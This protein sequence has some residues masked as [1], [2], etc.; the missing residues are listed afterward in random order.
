MTRRLSLVVLALLSLGACDG[1]GNSPRVTP[2]DNTAT[3][4]ALVA[5][6][7]A[8]ATASDVVL[9][10]LANDAGTGLTLVALEGSGQ[11]TLVIEANRVRY[12]PRCCDVEIDVFRYV[13]RDARG[14]QASAEVRV[15]VERRVVLE[16]GGLELGERFALEVYDG[17]ATLLPQRVVE[18]PY[19]LEVPFRTGTALLRAEARRVDAAGRPSVRDRFVSVLGDVASLAARGGVDGVVT[20]AEWDALRLSSLST[21]LAGLLVEAHDDATLPIDAP[22]WDRWVGFP[23][24]TDVLLERARL[25][26]VA[27]TRDTPLPGGDTYA[28]ARSAA[29]ARAFRAELPSGFELDDRS[30]VLPPTALTAYPAG[31]ATELWFW[32]GADDTDDF[33]LRIEFSPDGARRLTTP[34]GQ[35]LVTVQDGAGL[36]VATPGVGSPTIATFGLVTPTNPICAFGHLLR[37]PRDVFS[38]NALSFQPIAIAQG[39]GAPLRVAMGFTG[40]SVTS[41]SPSGC[42]PFI[43]PEARRPDRGLLAGGRPGGAALPTQAEL[44]GRWLVPYCDESCR[45]NFIDV[46]PMPTVAVSFPVESPGFIAN[47]AVGTLALVSSDGSIRVVAPDQLEIDLHGVAARAAARRVVVDVRLRQASRAASEA[48]FAPFDATLDTATVLREHTMR[49]CCSRESLDGI[50]FD[51]EGRARI[52][53]RMLATTREADGSLTIDFGD[54]SPA[55]PRRITLTAV[56]RVGDDRVLLHVRHD[57]AVEGTAGVARLEPVVDAP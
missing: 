51:I 14:T 30:S 27:L 39:V 48:W 33:A 46:R 17:A 3:T 18:R 45:G 42:N 8:A 55:S 47:S 44:V 16:I 11:A 31:R 32:R 4:L 7:V 26:E 34:E 40:L 57:G 22:T 2:P 20:A 23:F 52:G 24:A 56:Q 6:N 50:S 38:A 10:V 13:A 37:R 53:T 41:Y 12:R 49:D 35:R 21:A 43:R 29:N 1:S 54:I 19:R 28:L 9:H 5:D 36:G 15:R 25:V